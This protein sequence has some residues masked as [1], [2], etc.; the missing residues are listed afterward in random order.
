MRGG[1]I[2]QEGEALADP[3][4]P[5]REVVPARAQEEGVLDVPREQDIVEVRRGVESP[6]QHFEARLVGVVTDRL[7]G[8]Q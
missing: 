8:L 1:V 5:E 7:R 3:L 2:A 4:R 6:S